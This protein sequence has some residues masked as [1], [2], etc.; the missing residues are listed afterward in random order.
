MSI[1]QEYDFTVSEHLAGF[2]NG[3]NMK[4]SECFL[5]RGR[6]SERRN[7]LRENLGTPIRHGEVEDIIRNPNP[8]E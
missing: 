5:E 1:E 2:H 8:L 3:Y 7:D 4:C 6:V